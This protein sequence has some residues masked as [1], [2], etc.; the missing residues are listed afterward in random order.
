MPTFKKKHNLGT[1]ITCKDI[2]PEQ[3]FSSDSISIYF[4]AKQKTLA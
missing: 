4:F 2:Q 3:I 1:T